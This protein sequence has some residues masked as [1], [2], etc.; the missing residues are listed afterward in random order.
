MKELSIHP[1]SVWEALKVAWNEKFGDVA[2]GV[3]EASDDVGRD[4]DSDTSTSSHEE[5]YR[6]PEIE[7]VHLPSGGGMYVLDLTNES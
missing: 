5:T 4:P 1:K 3:A 6:K 2:T 7:Y